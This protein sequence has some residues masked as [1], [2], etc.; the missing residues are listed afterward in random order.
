[1]WNVL[2]RPYVNSNPTQLLVHIDV[3]VHLISEYNLAKV[4]VHFFVA[5]I[6]NLPSHF[7]ILEFGWKTAVL[8]ATLLVA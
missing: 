4:V 3:V 6:N 8:I 7:L 5:I 2:G 1:M